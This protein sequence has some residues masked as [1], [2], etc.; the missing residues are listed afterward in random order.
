LPPPS[1][2]S[3]FTNNFER[4][5]T[6][7]SDGIW[8]RPGASR[9]IDD[10]KITSGVGRLDIHMS[11]GWPHTLII[12]SPIVDNWSDPG[13]IT[14]GLRIMGKVLGSPNVSIWETNAPRGMVFL[15]GDLSNTFTGDVEVSDSNVLFLNK[16][17]GA[18]A[19]SGNV[20][21][22][23]GSSVVLWRSNQIADSSTVTLDGRQHMSGFSFEAKNYSMQEKFYR[24]TVKGEGVLYFY[25]RPTSRTLFLDDLLIEYGGVL[26]VADWVYSYCTLLVRK[27]SM[28]LNESLHRI[29]FMGHPKKGNGL[30]DSG[31]RDYWEIVPWPTPEPATYGAIFGAVGLGLA[32]WRKRRHSPVRSV[33]LALHE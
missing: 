14:V 30:K 32:S 22:S 20:T 8:Q 15:G 5:W 29:N 12:N 11:Y 21:V 7:G 17:G 26:H 16:T 4:Y 10:P 31:Y 27:D 3:I 19:I 23:G 13:P 2:A 18:R 25:K 24:L 33:I 28:H 6:V 1:D 9:V